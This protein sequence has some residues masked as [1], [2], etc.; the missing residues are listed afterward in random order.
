MQIFVIEYVISQYDG[1]FIAGVTSS[2][3]KAVEFLASE[4]EKGEE[5]YAENPFNRCEGHTITEHQVDR[6]VSRSD[7][8]RDPRCR[9]YDAKG[10]E[11]RFR[12][13]RDGPG[14]AYIKVENT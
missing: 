3:D 13:T 5:R 2:L 9:F 7:K 4:Y 1:S 11:W 10:I 6:L 8:D 12:T 14:A